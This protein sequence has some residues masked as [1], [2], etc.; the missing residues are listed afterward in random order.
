MIK[1]GS[2]QRKRYNKKWE[3]ILQFSS[4]ES[5]KTCTIA[6]FYLAT[7]MNLTENNKQDILIS[8]LSPWSQIHNLFQ[9]ISMYPV[10]YSLTD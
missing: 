10:K 7:S 4:F 3:K 9:D 8:H 5:I 6:A 1:F 2:L